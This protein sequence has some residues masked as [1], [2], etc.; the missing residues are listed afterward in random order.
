[1]S[2]GYVGRKL[3]GRSAERNLY[4]PGVREGLNL[5]HSLISIDHL[6]IYP[7]GISSIGFRD[8]AK[9]PIG[10]LLSFQPCSSIGPKVDYRVKNPT[11]P[12][13]PFQPRSSIGPKLLY[14]FSS[15]LACE[16]SVFV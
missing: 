11:G 6:G 7:K 3:R 12:L 4:Q 5:Q 10:P 16:Q 8:L 2:I 9:K 13:L 15:P 14:T 1:M